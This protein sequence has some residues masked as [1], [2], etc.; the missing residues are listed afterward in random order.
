MLLVT[1]VVTSL[2]V[3]Y[4][5]YEHLSSARHC[6]TLHFC[7]LFRGRSWGRVVAKLLT[8]VRQCNVMEWGRVIV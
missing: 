1:K 3:I 5:H 7:M 6:S 4:T 2:S 8:C